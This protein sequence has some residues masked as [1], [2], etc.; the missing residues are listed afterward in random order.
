MHRVS[1][2]ECMA[3]ILRFN[4]LV[5][6]LISTLGSEV[7]NSV[8]TKVWIG[9]I[10][11]GNIMN[12]FWLSWDQPKKTPANRW[13]HYGF[14]S[15]PRHEFN[16]RKKVIHNKKNTRRPLE[17]LGWICQNVGFI[18]LTYKLKEKMWVWGIAA[19]WQTITRN[20]HPKHSQVCLCYLWEA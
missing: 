10:C 20:D 3:S 12:L 18:C 13:L 11:M 8:P 16:S 17:Y 1:C 7:N 6:I 9:H 14:V 2:S 19:K 5:L 15:V 4:N